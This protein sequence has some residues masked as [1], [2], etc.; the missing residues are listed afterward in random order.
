MTKLEIWEDIPNYEGYYQVSNCGQVRS[1]ERVTKSKNGVICNRKGKL[2]KLIWDD[3]KYYKVSLRKNGTF[4]QASV[5][6]LVAIVF[7]N[8]TPCGYERV[9]NHIDGNPR[10]NNVDNLEITTQRDNTHKGR[11]CTGIKY[12]GVTFH[13]ATNKWQARIV[14]AGKRHYLGVFNTHEQATEAADKF[15]IDNGISL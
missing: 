7:L 6:Q 1:V 12:P 14:I 10:N 8:H 9:I 13:K 3:S 4:K 11:C 2:L 15:K 5:H